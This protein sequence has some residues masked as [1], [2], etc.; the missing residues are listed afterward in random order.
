ME[1]EIR[2]NRSSAQGRM[3][4]QN[5]R[6]TYLQLMKQRLSNNEARR[7]LGINPKTGPRK[8]LGWSTPENRL[9]ALLDNLSP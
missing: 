7:I 9:C 3:P 4:L 5:E 1:F 8:I 6:A 2:T